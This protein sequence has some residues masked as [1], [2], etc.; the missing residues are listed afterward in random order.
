[1]PTLIAYNCWNHILL[2]PCYHEQ[3]QRVSLSKKL[4]MNLSFISVGMNQFISSPWK[5]WLW[6]LLLHCEYV[7]TN[8]NIIF[9]LFVVKTKYPK[10]I[11][12]WPVLFNVHSGSVL[13]ASALRLCQIALIILFWEIKLYDVR[14]EI[15]YEVWGMSPCIAMLTWMGSWIRV[16]ERVLV[17]NLHIYKSVDL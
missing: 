12:S 8:N 4:Q 15:R 7:K 17:E 9:Q 1:M 13:W 2:M 6:E 11:L 16:R 3:H 10:L 5:V 14:K